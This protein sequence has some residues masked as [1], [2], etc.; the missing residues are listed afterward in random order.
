MASMKEAD[1][2]AASEVAK[3]PLVWMERF[4][5]LRRRHYGCRADLSPHSNWT[6]FSFTHEI[7]RR[8]FVYA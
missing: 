2:Y 7:V 1:V 8:D 4:D 3:H 6:F 5:V